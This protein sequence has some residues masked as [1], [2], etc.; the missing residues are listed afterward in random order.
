[1]KRKRGKKNNARDGHDV[2]GELLNDECGV[3]GHSLWSAL[4]VQLVAEALQV[5]HLERRE[6]HSNRGSTNVALA[7]QRPLGIAGRNAP[8]SN[9]SPHVEQW[10]ANEKQEQDVHILSPY[11]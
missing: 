1:M 4:N 8:K 10:T 9:E 11:H 7:L 6:S 3:L 5:L 2:W